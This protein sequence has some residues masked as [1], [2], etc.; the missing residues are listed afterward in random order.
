MSADH[1]LNFSSAEWLQLFWH[2]FQL[3]LLSIGGAITM[4]A[5]MYHF[6]VLQQHWL[7]AQQFSASIAIGQAS[8]GPNI[9]FVALLGWH[10][11]YN[12][13]NGATALLGLLLALGGILIPCMT[14]CYFAASWG[15]ANRELKS[16]RAFKLGMSPIS[17]GLILAA[18]WTL[19]A[20]NSHSWGDWPL[21]LLT[22]V[23]ALLAWRTDLHVLWLLAI[24]ALL[25]WFGWV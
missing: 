12:A 21:W 17:L 4:V 7:S 9:L 3:S 14:L 5:Q 1:L 10:V 19:V 6:L 2:F 8:P 15:H 23:C 24:G 13:G 25:G 22:A 16:V 18:G 11:G 20:N